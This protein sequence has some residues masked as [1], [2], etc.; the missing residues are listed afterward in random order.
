MAVAYID[1]ITRHYERLG[2]APYRWY[3]AP[4]PPP[5]TPLR[6]P[7]SELKLGLLSTAGAYVAGQRAFHDKSAVDHALKLRSSRV[8]M[9]ASCQLQV[10][11]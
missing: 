3:Q 8:R 4:D 1:R 5:W 10:V 2:Y 11:H 9:I 7:L 6:K